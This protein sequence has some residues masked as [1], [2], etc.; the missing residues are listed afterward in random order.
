MA[1]ETPNISCKIDGNNITWVFKRQT[2]S[3][4]KKNKLFKIKL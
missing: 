3:F 4:Q 1:T 2:T